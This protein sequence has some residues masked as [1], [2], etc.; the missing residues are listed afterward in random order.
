M[1]ITALLELQLKPESPTEGYRVVHETLADTRAFAGCVSVDV[2]VDTT[3]PAHVMVIEVWESAEA[4]AAYRE[5]RAGPGV[6]QLG[7]VLSA[8]PTLTTYETSPSL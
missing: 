3:D 7:S 8:Q 4:D 2:L 5:W 1:S 6:S